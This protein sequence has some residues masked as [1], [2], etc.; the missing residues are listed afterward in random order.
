[1]AQACVEQGI[2]AT[3]VT[4]ETIRATLAAMGIGWRRVKQH[5]HSPDPHYTVKKSGATG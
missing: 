3:R 2:T 1:L 4:G 5:I